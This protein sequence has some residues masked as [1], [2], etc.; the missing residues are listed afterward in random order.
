MPEG[1][2]HVTLAKQAAEHAGWVILDQAA[3]AAGA[4]G[5]DSFFAFEA[6]KS[7]PDRRYD[8]AGLGNRM[9]C[10]RTGAFLRALCK[11]AKSQSQLDYFM[12]FLAHYAIDT[13][14]HPFVNAVTQKGQLYGKKRGHG[15]FEIALDSY[16]CKRYAKKPDFDIDDI[17]PKLIGTSL[18][19][20]VG[21]LERALSETYEIS[22]PREYI[23]DA[24]FD[25][26]RIRSLFRSRFGFKR[27]FFWLIE[28][29]FGGRGA[30][31][32][33]VHPRRLRGITAKE[34][35][36]KKALPNPWT[37]PTTGEVHQ[38]SLHQ[39][40]KRAA[41]RT[42]EIYDALLNPVAS[43]HFWDVLGSYDYETGT[44]TP[45]ST[46]DPLHIAQAR[47]KPHRAAYPDQ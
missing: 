39:L 40:L 47:E 12:G 33:H 6:W 4:N 30:L 29:L 20:V 32:T 10:E 9:H 28:P 38:E 2:T 11:E 7:A 35:Q 24:F 26:R 15:Y 19:E 45:E 41:L 34:R 37:D 23:V 42:A 25:T 31:T 14:V 18:A 27:F 43:T 46:F 8:L 44:E 1:F 22:V 3:F 5:P 17:S 21:Q 13:T 36:K 16:V